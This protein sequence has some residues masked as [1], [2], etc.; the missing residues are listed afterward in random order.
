MK[1]LSATAARKRLAR[2]PAG[3]AIKDGKRLERAYRF[4]DF[5]AALAFVIRVGALAEREAHH[6]DIRLSWGKAKVSITTHDAGGLTGKD[7]GLAAKIGD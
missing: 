5:K 4:P 3:W 2:L 6:P 7:F 1:P